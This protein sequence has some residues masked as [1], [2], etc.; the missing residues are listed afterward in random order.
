MAERDRLH[1][2]KEDRDTQD[3]HP[4]DNRPLGSRLQLGIKVVLLR[5]NAI[6]IRGEWRIDQRELGIKE[7][8]YVDRY[9]SH[10]A[11]LV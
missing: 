1:A 8:S 2:R 7:K 4:T 9:I 11:A 5:Q 10:K 3:S 6:T